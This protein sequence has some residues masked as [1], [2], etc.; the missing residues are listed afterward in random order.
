MNKHETENVRNRRI[1][2][3]KVIIVTG[4]SR[5]IGR[6]IA[7]RLA[8]DGGKLVLAARDPA[9]LAALLAAA[10]PQEFIN[11]VRAAEEK[12]A[13]PAGAAARP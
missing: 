13:Q 10:T 4:A 1:L 6:S 11:V 9:N 8:Q 5:G 2:E 7:L 12:L 3:D